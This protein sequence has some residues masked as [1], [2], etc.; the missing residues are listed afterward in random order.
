[1][2]DANPSKRLVQPKAPDYLIPT[3]TPEHIEKMLAAC[4]QKTKEG[5]RNYVLLLVLLDTGM[6][7]SEL[8]GLRVN[9]VYVSG[10]SGAYV[11]VF[12]TGRKEREIG[13]LLRLTRWGRRG[14]GRRKSNSD[15]PVNLLYIRY[16]SDNV[17]RLFQYRTSLNGHE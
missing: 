5:F 4:D 16:M 2:L 12:G 9:D 3:F 14:G 17:T 1:M 8:C 10:A 13:L 7:V 6:R 15:S 11:K